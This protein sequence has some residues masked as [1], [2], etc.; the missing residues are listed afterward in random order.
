MK[1]SFE[2]FS[3]MKEPKDLVCSTCTTFINFI[4]AQFNLGV[5][6]ENIIDEVIGICLTLPIISEV[7][8]NGLIKNYAVSLPFYLANS[9]LPL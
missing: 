3:I 8:C 5:S 7:E 2:L 4:V 1:I 6:V 9:L